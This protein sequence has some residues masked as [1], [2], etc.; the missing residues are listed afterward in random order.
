M[1]KSVDQEDETATVMDK[2]KIEQGLIKSAAT[3]GMAKKSQS[4]DL[5]R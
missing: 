3:N 4:I 1:K 2:S 5:R